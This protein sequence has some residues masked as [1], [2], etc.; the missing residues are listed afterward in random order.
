[1]RDLRSVFCTVGLLAASLLPA[2]AATVSK[3][4][5]YF[6]IGGS[7][8][9][10][11]ENEL[12]QRGPEVKSTGRRH[13][14]ATQMEFT[15]RLTYAEKGDRCWISDAKVNMRA[16]V[17]LP[18]WKPKAKADGDVRLIWE[19]LASDIKRHEESHIVIA[20]NYA[21]ELE[22]SLKSIGRQKSCTA[23]AA[24]AQ[25]VQTAVLA[26]HDAAQ[27]RFDKIEGMNFEKRILSLLQYRLQR[28][29]A[30]KAQ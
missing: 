14:G 29:K 15:T 7:T 6:S 12:T 20:R 21:R 18:R 30:A 23:A 3:T 11:I 26:R 9:E 10:E 2:H 27:D 1:M 17:T 8:L 4:Y 19:T 25:A 24:K 16:K 5:S 22:Q 28:M 13:P